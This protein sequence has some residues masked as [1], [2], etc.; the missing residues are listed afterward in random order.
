MRNNSKKYLSS[1]FGIKIKK[2]LHWNWYRLTF[3]W[4]G[5]G[6]GDESLELLVFKAI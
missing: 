4:R 3:S 5:W 2:E 6:E 1:H